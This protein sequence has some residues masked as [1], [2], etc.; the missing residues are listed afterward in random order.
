[1][2]YLAGGVAQ[3]LGRSAALDPST[4]LDSSEMLL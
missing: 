1:M 3:E 4:T 2:T